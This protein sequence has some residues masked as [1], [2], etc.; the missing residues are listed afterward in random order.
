MNKIWYGSSKLAWVLW[1]F[2]LLYRFVIFCRKKCYQC[3]IFRSEA[4]PVPVIIVGNHTVGGT[5][6]TP[7]VIALTKLLQ[8][9]GHRV[10]II[11]RGYGVKIKTPREVSTT[12]S[13]THVGDEACVMRQ[14]LDTPIFVGPN[15]LSTAKSLL[16]RYPQTTLILSDDGLQHYALKR[17]INIILIDG[18]R[19]F[20]NNFCLP[21]GPL[22]EP[23]PRA[24]YV[25]FSFYTAHFTPQQIANVADPSKT[26]TAEALKTKTC[27]AL[28]GIA[29]P[30]K[31]FKTLTEWGLSFKR[32][33]YKD[34]YVYQS[35]DI[36]CAENQYLIMTEKDAVKCKPFANEKHW[37]V[38]GEMTLDQQ[39]CKAINEIPVPRAP[40]VPYILKTL[41]CIIH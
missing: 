19:G 26:I 13:P 38:R 41:Y 12:P 22:R 37:F 1:P 34:H 28:A 8:S 32:R 10:G 2:S 39:F 9:N 35:K 4:L 11:S 7:M 17:D 15:R 40:Y 23:V 14:H 25:P 5:G 21:A 30:D 27:I 24:P 18:S 33:V 20:G 29:N 31:F 36:E 6:K 16:H 3:H